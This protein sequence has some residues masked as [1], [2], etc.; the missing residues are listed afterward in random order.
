MH[1]AFVY[2]HR[3]RVDQNLLNLYTQV[4]SLNNIRFMFILALSTCGLFSA[5]QFWA[6][7]ACN[8]SVKRLWKYVAHS[9]VFV[10]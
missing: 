9:A 6:L 3:A 4:H 7:C 2:G 10:L 5:P 1:W 8:I